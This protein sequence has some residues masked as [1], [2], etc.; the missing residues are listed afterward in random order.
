MLNTSPYCYAT[1]G[2]AGSETRWIQDGSTG[3]R[4]RGHRRRVPL[5]RAVWHSNSGAERSRPAITNYRA[6]SLLHLCAFHGWRDF[7]L[8]V[9]S[10]PLMGRGVVRL[11]WAVTNRHAEPRRSRS[12]SIRI[13]DDL[14]STTG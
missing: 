9:L 5:G 13:W 4:D 7:R 11:F 1:G 12:W 2:S 6:V 8:A 14:T 3:R 10:F